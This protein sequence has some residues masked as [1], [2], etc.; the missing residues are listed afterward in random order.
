MRQPTRRQLLSATA[1][2][3]AATALGGLAPAALAQA[4]A[5][6]PGQGGS[7]GRPR[8]LAV[9]MS[10]DIQGALLPTSRTSFQEANIMRAVM[11]GLISFK[12]G[13]F[14]WELQAA[15][16]IT[17]VSP[18][19]ISFELRPGLKWHDGSG[20]MTAEDVKFS[21]ESFSQPGPDGRPSTYKADWDALDHVEVTGPLSGR[22]LLKKPAPQLWTVVLP[23]GSGLI[24]SRKALE[25]GAYRT[26]RQPLRVI[27]TGPYLFGEWVPNQRVVLRRNPDW[28]GD[29]PDFDEIVVRPV[30]DPK[31]AELALRADEL[32]FTAVEPSSA[33][34]VAKLPA[35]RV[36]NQDSINMVWI[37][38]NVEK[39]PFTD[40]RVR[41]AIRLALDPEQITQ[42]GYDGAVG[43]ATGPIA[44]PL[45]GYWK[46][47]PRP[48]RDVAAAKKL[49]AEA[50]MP[51]GFRTR[52]TLLNR[53]VFQNVGVITQALLAEVGIQL[54]L[55]VQD[56]GTFWSAGSGDA[57][58][59]L[60]LSLQRFGGK[61]D[62][63][64]QLQWFTADQVGQWNWER[65][66][67]PEYDELYRRAG[68]TD[69]KAERAR[70][71]IE[72]QKVMEA[73]AAFIWLTH[74]KNVMGFRDW[75]QP[76]VMPN[77]DDMLL[78]RFR[79]A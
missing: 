58:K 71:Y 76:A 55:D 63:A 75:L 23:E 40:L 43:T 32:Q 73:S 28:V 67:S 1:S 25:A 57:G 56:A 17:Q 48:A 46:D 3:S 54:D 30:R 72:A 41:Q 13:T 60:D 61:A 5:Q 70:L 68:A 39:P 16:S 49:L 33:A 59:A 64:F 18:T 52:L 66:R 24:Y 27:G 79:S 19:E 35:T 77:G 29:K 21:F 38:I 44:P 4:A 65:W 8:S 11:Q 51:N 10:R 31:T 22:I 69:D 62:P 78:A 34:A 36:L 7:Q 2:L 50:G 42:G 12:P 20:E 26:D 6:G 74:E 9:A 47:A 37:G 14:D 15:R 53:P 45:L